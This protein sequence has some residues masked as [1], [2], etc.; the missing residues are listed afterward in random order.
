MPPVVSVCVVNYNYDRFLPAAIDSA[1]AQTG[2]EVEVVVVDDGSTDASSEVIAGYGDRVVAVRKA[3]GGQGSAFN[4]GFATCSGDLVCFLDA[5]DVLEPEMAAL[6][7]SE[8]TA[9]PRLSK[10]QFMMRLVDQEGSH[11]GVTVPPRRGVQP[12][13]DLATHVLRFRTYPW[14]PSSA[15]VYAARALRQ[16]LPLHVAR[17]G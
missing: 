3:N 1:L 11:L 8:F 14:P 4:A 7:A 2:P 9:C 15:N 16:V 13:G 5:D 17:R 10:V 6:A 12:S